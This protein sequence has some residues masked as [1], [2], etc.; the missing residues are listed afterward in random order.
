[1]DQEHTD[2]RK[3]D[4]CIQTHIH[5]KYILQPQIILYTHSDTHIY[6]YMLMCICTHVCT[7]LS[8]H[9]GHSRILSGDISDKRHTSIKWQITKKPLNA[10]VRLYTKQYG[11]TEDKPANRPDISLAT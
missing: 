1:M 10:T 5:T 2:S 11:S 9:L 8:V 7:C 4:A 3:L 6:I